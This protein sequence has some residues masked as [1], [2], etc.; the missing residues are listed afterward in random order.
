MLA[1]FISNAFSTTNFIA[2]V[3]KTLVGLM[4]CCF[5]N[6]SDA[7]T[8]SFEFNDLNSIKNKIAVGASASSDSLSSLVTNGTCWVRFTVDANQRINQVLVKDAPALLEQ[9]IVIIK[10]EA[11]KLPQGVGTGT[12]FLLPIYYDYGS[13]TNEIKDIL[14]K[15]PSVELSKDGSLKSSQKEKVDFNN[16]FGIQTDNNNIG[17]PV[18]LLPWLNLSGKIQ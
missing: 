17:V 7:Q 16:F 6:T 18:I 9:L 14:D 13:P 8:Q 3:Q 10:G 2:I 1:L 15:L 11:F 4:L 12:Q 5:V